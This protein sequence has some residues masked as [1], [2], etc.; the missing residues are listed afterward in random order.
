MPQPARSIAVIDVGKTNAKVVLVDGASGADLA[1]RSAPTIVRQDGPYPHFD[2]SGAW[3]FL[4]GAL[5]D[6]RRE[7]PF[8]A[9]SIT[10]HGS[11]GALVGCDPDGEGLL[12]PILDYE[13]PGPEETA[14]DYDAVR[15]DF[16]ETLS[17]RLPGGLNLGAQIFWQRRRFPEAFEPPAQYVNYPQYWAW[18]F[19]G[20]LAT[21]MCSMGAHSD[22]WNPRRASWSSLVP[23]LGW[24]HI[25]APLRSAFDTLGPLRPDLASRLGLPQGL[26]VKCG[27]HDSSASLLPHLMV[28]EPPFTVVSTGTWVIL[29]AVGGDLEKLDPAKDTLANNSAFGQPVACARFMGGREFRI[30]AGADPP[31]PSEAEL[32]AVLARRIMAL[33]TFAPGTGPYGRRKGSWSGDP[34]ALTP[35]E[36][37]AAASL[38]DALVTAASMGAA[39]SAGPVIVEGP[40]AESRLYCSALA[41]ATGQPVLA[42]QGR[43]GT[44]RGAA[45]LAGGDAS[46]ALTAAEVSPLTSSHFPVYLEE[47]RRHAAEA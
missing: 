10:A 35:G 13:H 1:V 40:F 3:D 28:R 42:S 16:P 36:R 23:R 46:S 5:R 2:V 39:D 41:A 9:I 24:Y 14:D 34:A 37:S 26:P 15:P 38:Y 25:L 7:A 29:F 47:W 32:E 22:L 31:T 8:D 11:A 20:V 43:A 19:T 12:L 21:E 27:I 4:C 44:T 18:R 17:P 33:P 6:L 30:L 45:L